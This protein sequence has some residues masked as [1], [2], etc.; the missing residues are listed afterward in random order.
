MAGFFG[1]N[2]AKYATQGAVSVVRTRW[3]PLA[4]SSSPLEGRR[5]IKI[6]IRGNA[7]FAVG[8]AYALKNTDG[9]FT[10][11]TDDIRLVTI[12]PGGSYIIE[13]LG[14]SVM[15]YGRMLAKIGVTNNS[16]RV[17]VTEYA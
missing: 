8:L 5:Q 4:V 14:D 11:P 10:T 3:T 6:Y 1:D 13:P 16:V 12:Y 17:I 15:V 7:G 2:V 9:T